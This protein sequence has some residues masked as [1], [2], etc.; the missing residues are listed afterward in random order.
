MPDVVA[1]DADPVTHFCTIGWRERR[2][3]N[4]YFNTDW[5]AATLR[6]GRDPYAHD[7]LKNGV[8]PAQLRSIGRIAA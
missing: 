4:P 7:R 5:Y 8:A 1:A 3:P 6:P 2:R